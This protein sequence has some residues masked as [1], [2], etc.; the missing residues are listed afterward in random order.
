MA[1]NEAAANKFMFL[2]GDQNLSPADI[3][4]ISIVTDRNNKST[5]GFQSAFQN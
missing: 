5:G 4:N 1:V 2:V 3:V